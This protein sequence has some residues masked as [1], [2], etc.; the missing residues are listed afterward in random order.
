MKYKNIKQ[1]KFLER[2]NR[3]IAYVEIDGEVEV[4]HVK[5]TGRCRE[6]LVPGCT[7]Y[8]EES[9][10][11]NRKTRYDL[12]A[13]LK[14]DVLFN[15]DSQ[16]PNKVFGEW[17][18][19]SGYFGGIKH[20]KPEFTYKDSRLDFYAETENQK[21][22]IEVKGVTLEEDGVLIFP[23]APTIRGV[24]HIRELIGAMSEG[25]RTAIAFVI[26]TEYAKYFM[27]NNCTHPEFG[28]VLKEARSAGV[29]VIAL[30]CETTPDELK[31]KNIVEVRID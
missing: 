21:I 13:V 4:C 2:P 20:T 19:A 14:G 28:Q 17:L 15:I 29:E 3:F 5:N 22:L 27:P 24:K 9:S 23:D 1:G 25:Y 16:A 11:P 18:E 8:L 30:C 10:N 31:I 12:V 6:L 26:Q 7:V